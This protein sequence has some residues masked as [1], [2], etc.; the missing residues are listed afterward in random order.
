MRVKRP[1]QH[2]EII[3]RLWRAAREGR[4]PHALLFEGER[5]IGKFESAKWFAAGLLCRSGPGTP[6]LAC[7]PCKR[8]TSGGGQG[9]HP[10]LFVLDP[11]DPSD[12]REGTEQIRL[13]RIAYRP[14]AEVADPERCIGRFLELVPLEGGMKLVLVRESQRMNA[15]AQN[16]LLKTLEEPRPRTCL[17][18]ETHAAEL[19]LP[20]IRSRCVRIRFARLSRADCLR[21]LLSEGLVTPE[22]DEL[23]RW[24]EGSPGVALALKA[25]DARSIREH[26]VTAIRGERAPFELR[27]EIE[28]LDGAFEGDRASIRE[29]DRARTVIELAQAVL[30]DVVRCSAGLAEGELAHGD[31]AGLAAGNVDARRVE[32]ALEEL[33]AL[34]A[35]VDR[36][37]QPEAVLERA[38]LVLGQLGGIL[39][40]AGRP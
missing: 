18:L 15:E 1:F 8:V 5:G 40:A 13:F 39:G 2:G 9:N 32:R 19:L 38:L 11:L 34:R 23:A 4:L 14:S 21:V 37:L 25:R 16:A 20:T 27:S 3:E 35:D 22:A 24:S 36:N 7:P 17:V 28:A 6:C 30:R 12:E 31:L 26:L 33:V 29:R 10:D